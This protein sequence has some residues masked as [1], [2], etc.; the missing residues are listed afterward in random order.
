MQ[1]ENRATSGVAGVQIQSYAIIN[2]VNVNV[3]VKMDSV[4]IV[5]KNQG[6][7]L[8]L[9]VK[10]SV[11]LSHNDV[12]SKLNISSL[13]LLSCQLESLCDLGYSE[14][15]RNVIDLAYESIESID[16]TSTKQLKRFVAGKD[17]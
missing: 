3:V 7:N 15:K 5:L 6:Y 4:L 8:S 11:F 12:L 16:L 9:K 13:S 14:W 1:K 10:S 17:I 2:I